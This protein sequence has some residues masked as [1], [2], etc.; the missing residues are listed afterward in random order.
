M[1]SPKPAT[2]SI[3]NQQKEVLKSLP[4]DDTRDF[5]DVSRG[6]VGKLKPSVVSNEDK[7]VVW[8]NDQYAFVTGDA[9]D[10]A[11]PSLWR[12]SKLTATDGALRGR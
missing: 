12:Q 5:D 10:T 11:N 8:D 4:F 2:Q 7:K 6:Y 1:A 3:I 9:P